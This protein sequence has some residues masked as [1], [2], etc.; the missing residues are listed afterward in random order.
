MADLVAEVS[1]WWQSGKIEQRAL[2][3][4]LGSVEVSILGFAISSWAAAG[5]DA[6]MP[7]AQFVLAWTSILMIAAGVLAAAFVVVESLRN[8]FT[9]GTLITSFFLIGQFALLSALSSSSTK[10]TSYTSMAV[11]ASLVAILTHAFVAIA[12]YMRAELVPTYS[13]SSMTKGVPNAVA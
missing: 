9:F 4:V 3:V 1:K 5:K 2:L 8:E 11:F 10:I 12:W 6:Y 13:D 7:S